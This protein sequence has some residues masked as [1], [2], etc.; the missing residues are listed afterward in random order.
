[1]NLHICHG[2]FSFVLEDLVFIALSYVLNPGGTSDLSKRK[3]R[4][5]FKMFLFPRL[6]MIKKFLSVFQ[7]D[8]FTG[9]MGDHLRLRS[10]FEAVMFCMPYWLHH[11]VTF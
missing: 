3:K 6:Q 8:F 4:L 10:L 2:R 11:G 1:M 7:F 9:W 5:D